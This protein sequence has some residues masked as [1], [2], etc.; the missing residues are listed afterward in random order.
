MET[1]PGGITVGPGE[2]T[3]D[4]GAGGIVARSPDGFQHHR[5]DTDG[6][7]PRAGPEPRV[8]T[9]RVAH[10]SVPGKPEVLAIPT[11][12]VVHVGLDSVGAVHVKVEVGSLNDVGQVSVPLTTESVLT[13][14]CLGV[15]VTGQ[16]S[17]TIGKG[18]DVRV[19]SVFGQEI[20]DTAGNAQGSELLARGRVVDPIKF[21]RAVGGNVSCSHNQLGS[22][23]RP[24]RMRYVR[25]IQ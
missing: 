22:H 13:R 19:G 23:A 15:R 10:V 1:V 11:V 8:A 12:F 20:I 7:R 24:C 3:L 14:R 18:R 4:L 6:M 5:G 2:V 21:C 9:R 16:D 17:K 25:G